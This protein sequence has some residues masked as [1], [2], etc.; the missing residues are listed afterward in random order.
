MTSPSSAPATP[1][2]VAR[3][4]HWPKLPPESDALNGAAGARGGRG[5]VDRAAQ[6][7]GA[8][9]QRIGAVRDGDVARAQRVDRAVV[10]V[11]VGGG[12]RQ[13]ILQELDA[14]LVVV[15]G[16]EVRAAAGIEHV[17]VAVVALGPDAGHIAQQVGQLRDAAFVEVFAVERGDRARRGGAL[18]LDVIEDALGGDDDGVERRVCGLA[19]VGGR[20][21]ERQRQCGRGAEG[22]PVVWRCE[23]S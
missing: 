17:V 5:E 1:P 14:V 13:A 3:A 12:D 10:V 21:G 6:R 23:C 7:A 9:G 19:S 8:V 16:V 11:A 2:S 4:L 20:A 15:G 18:G 22:L